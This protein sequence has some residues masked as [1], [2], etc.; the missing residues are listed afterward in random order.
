MNGL[1]F[2]WREA[3]GNEIETNRFNR[4]MMLSGFVIF[5]RKDNAVYYT[6]PRHYCYK[7]LCISDNGGELNIE[8]VNLPDTHSS[9]PSTWHHLNLNAETMHNRVISVLAGE[10]IVYD[11]MEESLPELM[12]VNP[13]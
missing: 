10:A 3:A 4:L 5:V 2:G 11:K 8:W 1:L 7:M 13:C 6:A 12:Q 9:I